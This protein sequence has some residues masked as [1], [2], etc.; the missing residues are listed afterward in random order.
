[1]NK[2]YTGNVGVRDII[3][4]SVETRNSIL[5]KKVTWSIAVKKILFALIIT[6]SQS[7]VAYSQPCGDRRVFEGFLLD[8]LGFYQEWA[9]SIRRLYDDVNRLRSELNTRRAQCSPDDGDCWYEAGR[10]FENHPTIRAVRRMEE[11]GWQ[12]RWHSY[13]SSPNM[14]GIYTERNPLSSNEIQQRS[15]EYWL[16]VLDVSNLIDV[17]SNSS[18][19]YGSARKGDYYPTHCVSGF[20]LNESFSIRSNSSSY[21]V[22]EERIITPGVKLAITDPSHESFL[23]YAHRVALPQELLDTGFFDVFREVVFVRGAGVKIEFVDREGGG[24]PYQHFSSSLLIF[25]T[26]RIDIDQ[27]ANY[28]TSLWRG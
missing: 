1:M 24:Y 27:I 28:L 13:V 14:Y 10:A 4:S 2:F 18:A 15:S 11:G 6:F 21:L 7:A 26:N 19:L 22:A 12:G 9:Q 20:Y 25:D 23:K 3:M 5:S 16:T 17:I 8:Q